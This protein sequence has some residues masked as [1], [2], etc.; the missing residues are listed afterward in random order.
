MNQLAHALARRHLRFGWYALLGFALLGAGLE[1]LHAFK[2]AF[3]LDVDS[4]TRRLMWRLAHAHGVG[5]GLVNL[6]FA[7]TLPHVRSELRLERT[8]ACLIVASLLLPLG[9]LLGGIFAT[10]GDP[11]LP[12]VLV[13]LALPPLFAALFWIARS[14]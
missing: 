13:P 7:A 9:F 12:I 11:G 3:Y 1:V 6:G 10:G 14:L 4:E 2:I 5:L 8:S